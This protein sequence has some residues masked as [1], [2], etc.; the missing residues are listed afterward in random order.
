MHAASVVRECPGG[1]AG[2]EQASDGVRR[3]RALGTVAV[4]D[5][6]P[7]AVQLGLPVRDLVVR[8]AH[9][10]WDRA[11]SVGAGGP[12]VDQYGSLVHHLHQFQLADCRHVGV[13]VQ[14]LDDAPRRDLQGEADRVLQLIQHLSVETLSAAIKGISHWIGEWHVQVFASPVGLH[15][16]LKIWPIA[17]VATNAEKPNEV[18]V[19]L[20][21]FTR[22]DDEYEPTDLGAFNSPAGKL[23]GVFLSSC[24]SLIQEPD[25]FSADTTARQMRDVLFDATGRSELIVRYSLIARLPYFLHADRDWAQKNL[26]IPLLRDGDA[27]LALWRAIAERTHSTDVL[28]IIGDE[29]TVKATDRRL[30]RRT[31]RRLVFSLVRESLFAFHEKRDPAVSNSQIQQMLRTLDDEVRASAANAIVQIVPGLLEKDNQNYTGRST[32]L[33]QSIAV[34]F[35]QDVWPQERSLVTAGVSKAL[36]SL[37]ATFGDAFAEA[38]ETIERFLVPFESGSMV[39]YGFHNG[40]SDKKTLALINDKIKA[41]SFLRLLDLT[42]GSSD[43]AIIPHDLTDALKRIQT[44]A[45][46][47]VDSPA[48][49]RLSTAAR[50]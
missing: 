8:D 31:R 15:V 2:L 25:A 44:C 38:V 23:I 35:F 37:P 26:I 32:E 3:L 20:S 19:G 17:I 39:N 11:T 10:S 4:Q 13:G 7:L 34:P 43:G 27:S 5:R 24:P 1:V 48:F 33:F 30:S 40:N 12:A 45:P 16:W 28:R 14:P 22:D 41:K 46:G 42:I 50:R 29:M 6:E 9:R 36:A 47:L 49:L 21:V 18:S